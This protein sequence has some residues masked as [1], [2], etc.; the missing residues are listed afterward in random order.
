MNKRVRTIVTW[1]TLFIMV[2][3]IAASIVAYT[4]S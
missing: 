1:I 2:A 3:G 4:I